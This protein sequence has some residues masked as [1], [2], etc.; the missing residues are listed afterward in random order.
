MKNYRIAVVGAGPS[1]YFAVQ[2]LLNKATEDLQFQIDIIEKLPIPWGLVRWGVAPDHPKIKT[3]GKVFEKLAN[4]PAVNLY[5]NVSLDK[6]VTL[7]QLEENYDAVVIATGAPRG[8][9]LGIPGED[10]TNSVSAADFVTWYNGHFEFTDQHFDFS[11]KTA[12]V[13]GA[14]NVAMDCARILAIDPKELD[15]TDI[16]DYA[17]AKLHASKI[18]NTYIIARRSLQFAAFTAPE[19]RDLPKLENTHVIVSHSDVADAFAHVDIESADRELVHN[20]EAFKLISE[21]PK[22][23]NERKLEFKFA[24]TPKEIYG[25]EKVEGITFQV[26]KMEGDKAITTDEEVSISCDLVISAIGYE[27]EAISGIELTK[28]K[29]AN[30]EGHIRDQVYV[31]GWAKRG[32]S[33]VIGTNKHDAAQV[34]E[35]L[36]ANLPAPKNPSGVETLL[37]GNHQVINQKGWEKISSYEIAQGESQGRPRIKVTNLEMA[38]SLGL[39]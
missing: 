38:I 11:G 34:I 20:L 8:K 26:N 10:L 1:G 30:Q 7:A 27:S 15:E 21:T 5:G 18:T 31:V 3:V 13:I 12:V 32:P 24:L 36:I 22:S 14:G 16:A 39:N 28:G 37:S 33:G 9:K 19:L 23:E 4:D 25:N 29:F 6:D 17:L 2:A 35:K